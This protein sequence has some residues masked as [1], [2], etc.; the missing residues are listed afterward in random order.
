MNKITPVCLNCNEPLEGNYCSNCGQ[1]ATTHRFTLKHIFTQDFIRVMLYINKGFFYTLKELFTRP[2]NSVREY[3]SGKRVKHLNY[4]TLLIVVLI[5]FTIL[6]QVTPFHFA[7]LAEEQNQIFES[8]DLILKKYPKYL[9]VGIIPFYALF[10]LLIFKKAQQNYAEHVVLNTFRVAIIIILNILFISFAS[11][12]KDISIIRKGD[13]LLAWL[14][15]AYG[16][17]FYYQY[18]SPFYQN[19][20]MLFLKSLVCV[21]LPGLL[22]TLGFISYFILNGS[23]SF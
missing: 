13:T 10:S 23:L 22:L 9:Y 7:D 8:V 14:S 17:W 1:S 6:E 21:V 20:F 16:T 12:S 2:G 19:K 15:T 18:F 3:V 11:V 5:V 4:F